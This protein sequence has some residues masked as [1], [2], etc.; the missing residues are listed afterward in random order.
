MPEISIQR[1]DLWEGLGN[2]KQKDWEKAGI[3]LGL[4]VSVKGGKGSHIVIRDSKYPDP[5]DIR[6]LIATVQKKLAKQHNQTIFKHLLDHG[7]PE[8]DIWKALKMLK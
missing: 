4:N 6:G 2:I 3:R 7:I 1:R 5:V 8:D